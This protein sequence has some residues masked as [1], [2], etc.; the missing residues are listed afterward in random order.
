MTYQCLVPGFQP[1]P[2]PVRAGGVTRAE[3][4]RMEDTETRLWVREGRRLLGQS[5]ALVCGEGGPQVG[6]PRATGRLLGT[7]ST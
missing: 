7:G 1:V 5:G 2:F 6:E 3:T 4:M